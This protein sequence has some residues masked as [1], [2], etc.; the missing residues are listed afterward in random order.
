MLALSVAPAC[1]LGRMSENEPLDPTA[2]RALEPGVSTA[3]QV[4]A[5]L[6]APTDVVPIGR[7]SAYRYDAQKTKVAALVLIVFNM[8]HVD[9]RSDRVWV[10]FDEEDRLTHVAA[11]FASHRTKYA[12]PWSDVHS[13]KSMRKADAKR[14]G[15]QP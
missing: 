5:V 4:V 6:G 13:E 14:E 2:V 11:T 7:R 8:G 15:M 10:F 9:R 1:T 3:A 12:L